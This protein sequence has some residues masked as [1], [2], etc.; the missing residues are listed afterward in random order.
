MILQF[1]GAL[2]F[3]YVVWTWSQNWAALPAS[4]WFGGAGAFWAPIFGAVAIYST[5]AL[6]IMSLVALFGM[7]SAGMAEWAMKMVMWSGIAL[8]GLT[9]GSAW[10]LWVVVGFVLSYVGSGGQSNM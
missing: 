7:N 9:A 8:L 6:F 2:I 10:F 3:L 4:G 1:I 5:I